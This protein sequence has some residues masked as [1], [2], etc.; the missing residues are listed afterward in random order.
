[1]DISSIVGSAFSFSLQILSFLL[2]LHAGD[3][4]PG[5]GN[6]GPEACWAIVPKYAPPF[7]FCRLRADMGSREGRYG[8]T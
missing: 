5:S 6:Q 8:F 3:L 2:P 4:S 1:M 7:C